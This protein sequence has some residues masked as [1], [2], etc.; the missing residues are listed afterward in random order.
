MPSAIAI[1]GG[2]QCNKIDDLLNK[3]ALQSNEKEGVGIGKNIT[4]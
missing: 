1:E 4:R 2:R 3:L